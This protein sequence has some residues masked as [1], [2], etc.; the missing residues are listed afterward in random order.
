METSTDLSLPV[1][2]TD[3]NGI[4][5]GA[6]AYNN[7]E[8]SIYGQDA[9]SAKPSSK[10]RR[11]AFESH[12]G[13]STRTPPRETHLY[14]Y[15]ACPEAHGC[16]YGYAIA[17]QYVF[18]P[19]SVC[20]AG[21]QEIYF[22][23]I[24][25]NTETDMTFKAYGHEGCRVNT[26][27]GVPENLTPGAQWGSLDCGGNLVGSYSTPEPRDDEPK[28]CVEETEKNKIPNGTVLRKMT[29]CIF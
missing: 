15:A 4:W 22:H 27:A 8:F 12:I 26:I 6:V 9:S 20:D 18:S 25:S 13:I 7:I 3:A 21:F 11:T 29:V 14:A 28:V 17:N 24:D 5:D 2:P 16:D 23:S 1:G 19:P 10:H